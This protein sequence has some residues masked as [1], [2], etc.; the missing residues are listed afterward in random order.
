MNILVINGSPKGKNSTTLYAAL[1]M[2]EI[3]TD[4]I[5]VIHAAQKIRKYEQDLSEAVSEIKKAD[6]VIF[7]YPVYTFLIPSQLHRFIEITKKSGCY[8]DKFVTQITTSKHFYDTTAHAFVNEN[9]SDTK[10]KTILGLSLDMDDI[11]KEKGRDNVKNFRKKLGFYIENGIYDKQKIFDIKETKSYKDSSQEKDHDG[12]FEAVIVKTSDDNNVCEMI[13]TFKNVFRYKTKVV[14]LCGFEFTGGCLGCMDC[15]F[16]GACVYKDGFQ[17]L[18]RNDI[19]K[20][21]MIIYASKIE[22]HFLGSL[23]KTYDDRQFCN[24]HRTVTMGAPNGYILSG[25]YSKEENLKTV[26]TARADVGGNFLCGVATDEDDAEK[27]IRDLAKTCEF[28]LENKITVPQTFYGVGGLK[29]FRDMIYIMQG[30]MKEDHRFYKKHGFYDFPQ[31]QK[32][33]IFKMKMAGFALSSE[34]IKKKMAGKL[35]EIMIA[36]YQKV[37]EQAKNEKKL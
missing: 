20:S 7:S 2:G 17:E 23:M 16:T 26:L 21:S 22:D 14:D 25:E 29:I 11:L 12:D 33:T 36:P 9:M 35:G 8:E 32:G 18:L 1:Y 30:F 13:K 34:K 28:A 31:K 4:N 27:S 37:L 19:Q 10:A 3:F 15:A 5:T 24:G 6:L